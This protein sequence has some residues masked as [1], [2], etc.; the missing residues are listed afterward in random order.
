MA[1]T[2]GRTVKS[3]VRKTTT[4][5][6]ATKDARRALEA[7]FGKTPTATV[8]SV[9]IADPK[10]LDLMVRTVIT[11][12]HTAGNAELLADAVESLPGFV[13]AITTP[14]SVTIVRTV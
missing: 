4:V 3:G 13:R 10:T 2:S 12:P 5:T 11:F 6:S 1:Y 8:D 7:T 14:Q 9:R